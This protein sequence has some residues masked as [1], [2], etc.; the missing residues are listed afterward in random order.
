M[1]RAVLASDHLTRVAS[2]SGGLCR[3]DKTPTLKDYQPESKTVKVLGVAT[4]FGNK[5]PM[6]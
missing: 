2:F 4:G 5:N 6:F 3:R 1:V